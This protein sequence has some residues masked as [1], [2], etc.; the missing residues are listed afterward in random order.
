MSGKVTFIPLPVAALA[1]ALTVLTAGCG[2]TVSKSPAPAQSPAGTPAPSS[3]SPQ[4]SQA[5][6]VGD[7]FTI[8]SGDQKYDVTLISVE[9]Q[10][11][12][13]DEYQGV[14]AD[15]HLA[16]A[17][18]RVTAITKT[19][20]NSTDSAT[21][22]GS[23]EQAYTAALAEITAGTNFASGQILLQ[24]GGS[25]VGWVPFELPNGVR[26]AKV[27][28]TPSAGLS[29]SNAEWM[30][31]SSAGTSPS[32]A[33]TSG[34]TSTPASTSTQSAAPSPGTATPG[35]HTGPEQT[36]IAYFD[37]INQH[38]YRT[39][40]NLGG[41]NTASSYSSFVSGFKTTSMV[42]VDILDVSGDTAT[43]IVTA[44]VT[45][46]ETDGSTKIFEGEYTVKNGVIV[47]F[48]VHQVS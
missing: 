36:V 3:P 2:T 30:I 27:Q 20:E 38:D 1:A 10:A 31:S 47:E 32:A 34:A 16:A 29:T 40:W 6:Q 48:N 8:T 22:T 12:P 44:R 19:D 45:T 13:G 18:F 28:W 14:Q 33:T 35:Q 21:V 42:S 17:Q 15:H 41:K 26:I 23:N 39:A 24:P 37:A 46:L 11:Q 9:Q 4:A 5:G 25:L 7:K 43:A